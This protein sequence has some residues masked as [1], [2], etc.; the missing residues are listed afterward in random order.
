MS[1]VASVTH[2]TG[3]MQKF[4]VLGNYS[5]NLPAHK[6]T[7]L[8]LL[9]SS[10]V[11]GGDDAAALAALCKASAASASSACAETAREANRTQK[12]NVTSSRNGMQARVPVLG[13]IQKSLSKKLYNYTAM[14]GT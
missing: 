4:E 12:R 13:S 8:L 5:C 3:S 1:P 10:P 14:L 11:V 9:S 7:M 2:E 6:D